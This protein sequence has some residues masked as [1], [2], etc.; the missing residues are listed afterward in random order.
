MAVNDPVR[1]GRDMP[2][3]GGIK[4]NQFMDEHQR[5]RAADMANMKVNFTAHKVLLA[6]GTTTLFE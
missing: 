2:W 6:D 4:Y 3:V 5:L 1:A